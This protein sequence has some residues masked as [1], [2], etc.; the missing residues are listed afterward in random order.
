MSALR[1]HGAVALVALIVALGAACVEDGRPA[2]AAEGSRVCLNQKERRAAVESGSALRLAAAIHALRNRLPGTLVRARLCRGRDGL[3]YV[4]TVLAHDGK[5][6]R[7]SV[8][9]MKAGATVD[10]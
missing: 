4:L 2:R 5:V 7:I 9:A 1:R 3:V 8:D 10:R 6:A